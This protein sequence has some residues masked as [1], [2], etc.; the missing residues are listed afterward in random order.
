[1]FIRPHLL[2][3]LSEDGQFANSIGL[4]DLYL[5]AVVAYLQLDTSSLGR[6]F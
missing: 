2:S 6:S 1:M 5:M 3:L 4:T